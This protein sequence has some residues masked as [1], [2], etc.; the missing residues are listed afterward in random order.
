MEKLGW[1]S[2]TIRK[3][4][5]CEINFVRI[6]QIT[7]EGN[8]QFRI[9]LLSTFALHHVRPIIYLS[10]AGALP[11]SNAAADILSKLNLI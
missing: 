4:D 6:D 3:P 2:S 10:F 9:G 11:T 1:N 5:N 7:N 8:Y